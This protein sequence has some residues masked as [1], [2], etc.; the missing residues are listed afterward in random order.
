[1]QSFETTQTITKEEMEAFVT[2]NPM[3][4]FVRIAN[5]FVPEVAQI[6]AQ[7]KK[8]GRMARVRSWTSFRSR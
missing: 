4:T 2:D 1:M 3:H 8:A 5:Q 7:I 6:E